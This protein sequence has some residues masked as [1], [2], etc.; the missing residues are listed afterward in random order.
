MKHRY[1]LQK[2]GTPEEVFVEVLL[3][4]EKNILQEA[5]TAFMLLC[6][7]RGHHFEIKKY[8]LVFR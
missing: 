2:I 5:P 1:P 6:S 7:S 4:E 3:L 8:D